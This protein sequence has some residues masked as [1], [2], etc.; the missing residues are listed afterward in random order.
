MILAIVMTEG[1]L[2]LYL[3]LFG[4]LGVV[5]G[6]F[7][8]GFWDN[9]VAKKNDAKGDATKKAEENST[10]KIAEINDDAAT[11]NEL[12]KEVRF[13][14]QDYNSLSLAYATLQ[15]QY[16]ESTGDVR[17]MNLRIDNLE[18]DREKQEEDRKRDEARIAQLE[19]E[20]DDYKQ[21]LFRSEDLNAKLQRKL[22][23][24]QKAQPHEGET[25]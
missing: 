8:K 19:K 15:K 9:R 4:F 5:G 16:A 7:V 12:W 11:R 17:F 3:G 1:Q 22:D 14:R 6:P 21:Q 10:V 24:L 25:E 23:R 18:K 20:R 13:L 2:A